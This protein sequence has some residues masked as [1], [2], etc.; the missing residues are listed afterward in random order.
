MQEELRAALKDIPLSIRPWPCGVCSDF[1]TTARFFG[2]LIVFQRLACSKGR[3]KVA[4]DFPLVG[5]IGA[6]STRFPGSKQTVFG[7]TGSPAF[8][9]DF[10][11]TVG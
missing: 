4:A 3:G 6:D 7:G 2:R 9:S 10:V 5:W 1:V 8:S 11:T